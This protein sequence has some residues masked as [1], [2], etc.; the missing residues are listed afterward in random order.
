VAAALAM[1]DPA[2]LFWDPVVRAGIFRGGAGGWVSERAVFAGN[3]AVLGD[4]LFRRGSSYY[5]EL[6]AVEFGGALG[7]LSFLAVLALSAL[8]AWKVRSARAVVATAAAAALLA[9]ASTSAAAGPPGLRRATTIVG[10]FYLLV[11]ML[12]VLLSRLAERRARRT[13]AALLLLLPLHHLSAYADHLRQARVPVWGRERVWFTAAPTLRQSLEHWVSHTAQ[14]RPLDCRELR[15]PGK[16][17]C[18]YDYIYAAI[19]GFRLWNG[20]PAIEV[21][22]IDWRTG[23]PVV[24]SP[25]DWRSRAIPALRNRPKAPP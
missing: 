17:V 14:R 23:E 16:Q 4:D 7:S 3:L 20:E 18:G 6:R 25:Y 13:I 22:A 9:M 8:A 2:S 5:F 19:A 10:A 21:R 15:T 12:W 1:R 11:A 24:L